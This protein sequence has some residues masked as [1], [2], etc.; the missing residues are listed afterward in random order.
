MGMHTRRWILVRLL[1][2]TRL[3]GFSAS[4]SE[5]LSTAPLYGSFLLRRFAVLL[6]RLRHELPAVIYQTEL[7]HKEPD[8]QTMAYCT[9]ADCSSSPLRSSIEV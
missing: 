4:A 6:G 1:R 2:A 3:P 5:Y 8:A 9:A 7:M